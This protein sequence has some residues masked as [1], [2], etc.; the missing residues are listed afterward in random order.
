M[1]RNYAR[2]SATGTSSSQSPQAPGQ[3]SLRG[4]KGRLSYTVP[5]VL[6]QW[7]TT[8]NRPITAQ[9]TSAGEKMVGKK[10][11]EEAWASLE[12]EYVV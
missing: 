10:K 11:Q 5:H 1:R 12:G 2:H 4:E 7:L 9:S 6:L 3:V 8:H